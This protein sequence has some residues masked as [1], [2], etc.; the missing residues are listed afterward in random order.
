MVLRIHG[1]Y[2]LCRSTDRSQHRDYFILP[3]EYAWQRI[4]AVVADKS[5]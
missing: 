5:A 1:K 4:L 2:A 3:D